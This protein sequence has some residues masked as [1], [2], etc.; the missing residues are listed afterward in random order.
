MSF[1]A[2]VCGIALLLTGC[3]E[4][5]LRS[6]VEQVNRECPMDLGTAGKMESV[7]YE[8]DCVSFNYVFSEEYVSIE[9]MKQDPELIKNSVLTMFSNPQGPMKDFIQALTEAG[10][11]VKFN[12]Q[13]PKGDQKLSIDVSSE[14]LAGA[15]N[16]AHTTDADKLDA[17]LRSTNLQMPM[18]LGDGLVITQVITEGNTVFYLCSVDEHQLDFKLL[19]SQAAA[20]K[21]EITANLAALSGSDAKFIELIANAHKQLGYRYKG[22]TSGQQMDITLTTDELRQLHR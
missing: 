9:K 18:D 22:T 11:S 20:L 14:E 12:F 19:K 1:A 2:I 6:A 13:N 10:A 17:A 3:A 21:Q 16:D 8:D 15:R 5:K 7:S 4:N